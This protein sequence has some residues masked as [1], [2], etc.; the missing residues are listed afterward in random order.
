MLENLSE[1]SMSARERILETGEYETTQIPLDG[2]RF[3]V[4][5]VGKSVVQVLV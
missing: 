3:M 2:S 1:E 4:V 5:Q